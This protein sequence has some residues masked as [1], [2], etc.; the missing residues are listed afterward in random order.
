FRSMQRFSVYLGHPTYAIA[1]ILFSMI[2]FAGIG[3]SVSDRIPVER[4]PV[5]LAIVPLAIAVTLVGATAALPPIIR[6]PNHR[7]HDSLRP[8]RARVDRRRHHRAARAPPGMLFPHRA[9]PDGAH[10]VG[11]DGL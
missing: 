3:S 5:W 2:L 8:A 10:L 6:R 1:I 9:A 4:A 11:S 7:P